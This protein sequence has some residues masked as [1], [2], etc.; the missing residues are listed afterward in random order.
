M[1]PGDPATAQENEP[2]MGTIVAMWEAERIAKDY[3]V[4]AY[5]DMDA[6]FE[7]LRKNKLMGAKNGV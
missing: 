2:N 6:L 3:P 1:S 4:E 5:S 7:N